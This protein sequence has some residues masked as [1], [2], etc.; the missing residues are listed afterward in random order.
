MLLCLLERYCTFNFIAMLIRDIEMLQSENR[1]LKRSIDY[2]V[3]KNNELQRKAKETQILSAII[4][5][6]AISASVMF[7]TSVLTICLSY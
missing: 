2:Y 6:W 7:I 4:L 1:R 3:K 5:I